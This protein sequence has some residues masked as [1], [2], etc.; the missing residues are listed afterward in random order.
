MEDTTKRSDVLPSQGSRTLRDRHGGT[1]VYPRF[2]RVFILRLTVDCIAR[3]TVESA[4]AMKPHTKEEEARREAAGLPCIPVSSSW[5]I[6]L[7][8]CDD[9][10]DTELRKPGT[11]NPKK[12]GSSSNPRSRLN[13]RSSSRSR[14]S[15]TASVSST[16]NQAALAVEKSRKERRVRSGD[17]E[18][19]GTGPESISSRR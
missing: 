17:A 11:A 16:R 3:S 15:S 9:S 12:K 7:Q 19:Y 2:P 6:Q 18:A 1:I 8:R 10:G 5:R 4:I 13:S 14:S